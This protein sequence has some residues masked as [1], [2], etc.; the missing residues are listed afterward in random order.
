[1]EK[2]NENENDKTDKTK[3]IDNLISIKNEY[4]FNNNLIFS[5]K[6][7]LFQIDSYINSIKSIYINTNIN[8][9]QAFLNS[10]INLSNYL[11]SN[12]TIFFEEKNHFYLKYEDFNDTI[13]NK[14][15]NLNESKNAIIKI[16]KKLEDL[17]NNY[18]ISKEIKFSMNINKINSVEEILIN[19][20]LVRN[21]NNDVLNSI[22]N[23]NIIYN[24]FIKNYSKYKNSLIEINIINKEFINKIKKSN[25]FCK[26]MKNKYLC[27]KY[28]KNTEDNT[29]NKNI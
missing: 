17:I 19:P 26:D 2:L 27:S 3:L 24:K 28:M 7:S 6:D 21:I 15:S 11:E 14:I 4:I 20:V 5:K 29:T 9:I 22:K 1:M 25:I 12:L 18:T 16:R 23:I 13:L 10:L 8:Q